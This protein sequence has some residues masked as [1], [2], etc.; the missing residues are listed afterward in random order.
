MKLS[1]VEFAALFDGLD[2]TRGQAVK[3]IPRP[4]RALRVVIN[5]EPNDSSKS[6]AAAESS[7]SGAGVK[8]GRQSYAYPDHARQQ[9]SS[10]HDNQSRL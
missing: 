2:W 4:I 6:P 5:V 10:R 9:G 7:T 1:P 3:T 8:Q